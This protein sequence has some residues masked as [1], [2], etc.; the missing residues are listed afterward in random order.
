MLK[1]LFNVKVVIY[2]IY[3]I[4]F[5]LFKFELERIIRENYFYDVYLKFKWCFNL[6]FDFFFLKICYIRI[7]SDFENF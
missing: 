6:F 5:L 4:M 7:D 2:F 3:V 1:Q